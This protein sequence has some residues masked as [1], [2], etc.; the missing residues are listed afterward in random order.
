MRFS[1]EESK[2]SSESSAICFKAILYNIV[3]VVW[4]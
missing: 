1:S 2:W 3:L 4:A